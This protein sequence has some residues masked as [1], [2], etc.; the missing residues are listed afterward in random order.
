MGAVG[1]EVGS[2]S[3]TPTAATNSG[4]AEEGCTGIDAECVTGAEVAVECSGEG[5]FAVVGASVVGE[6]AAVAA[7]VVADAGDFAAGAWC[8][9]IDD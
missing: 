2:G 4:I 9:G 1:G 7:D 6:V 8:S 3:E 5:G